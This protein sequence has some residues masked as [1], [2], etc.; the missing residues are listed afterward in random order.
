LEVG[1]NGRAWA[2]ITEEEVKRR[3]KARRRDFIVV[4]KV[5]WYDNDEGSTIMPK[6]K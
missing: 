5:G 6:N 1:A 3:A 2:N 4:L